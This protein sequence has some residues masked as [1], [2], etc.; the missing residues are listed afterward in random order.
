MK[1]TDLIPGRHIVELKNGKR[2]LF[3]GTYFMGRDGY[4]NRSSVNDDLTNNVVR[5]C[6][7]VKVFN[8]KPTSAHMIFNVL[9]DSEQLRCEWCKMSLYTLQ[10]AVE[11]GKR[12]KHRDCSKFTKFASEAICNYV[13][14]STPEK[15]DVHIKLK[16]WEIEDNE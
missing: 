1:K 9:L 2:L 8:I 14:I 5:S 16:V 4:M 15:A 12:F 13:S 6:D 7:I 10:E 3:V 11:S